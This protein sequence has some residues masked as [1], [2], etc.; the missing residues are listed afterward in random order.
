MNSKINSIIDQLKD[1]IIYSAQELI[2]IK[3]VEAKPGE[4]MPFGQGVADALEKSLNI[5]NALGLN[6]KNIDGYAG[7]VEIGEGEEIMGI[8]CH[9]DI[10]PEGSDWTYPPYNAEIHENKIYGRGAIDNKGPAVSALFALKAVKEA[11]VKLN[12]R[13]RLILGTD[14]ESGWDGLEYYLKKETAPDF[15]FSPDASYPVI[16]AEKGILTFKV[17]MNFDKMDEDN[18]FKI[19][20]IKGGNAP[21]MV[22]DRCEAFIKY[23]DY[24]E[25]EMKLQNYTINNDCN[26]ELVREDDSAIIRAIGVSAHGSTPEEGVNAI[27][28][29]LVFLHSLDLVQGPIG[30]FLDHFA[31]LI[32]TEY[33]GESIGCEL[34]DDISGRLIF[35]VGTIDLNREYGEITVNI[36]YPVT[37]DKEDVFKGLRKAIKGTGF[38]LVEG[39]HMPPLYVPRDDQLVQDLMK[40]YK[41]I[42]GDDSKPIAIGGGTYARAVK[43]AVAFGPLFPGE[44]E[45]AHQKDEYI[46]IDDLLKNTKIYAQTIIRLCSEEDQENDGDS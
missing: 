38:E 4:G 10:V 8:L 20:A 23:N 27:S 5:A 46:E 43:R 3:S 26:I 34:S 17:K 31:K 14:E 16:F 19:T 15:S 18:K 37:M 11:G 13:V 42:T 28:H 41:E 39:E 45:L 7:H 1:D 21:N 2:K 36:R 30:N 6:S 33:Y 29:L 40:V 44:K 22:P 25:L 24:E 9:L 35:N 12:K 32:G